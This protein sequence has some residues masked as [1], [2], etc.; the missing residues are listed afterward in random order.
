MHSQIETSIID[1][2]IGFCS[3]LDLSRTWTRTKSTFLTKNNKVENLELKL[4]RERKRVRE[5]RRDF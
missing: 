4:E 3:F 1:L 2:K 5:K